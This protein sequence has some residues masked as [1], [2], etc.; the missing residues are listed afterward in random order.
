M[1]KVRFLRS[2]TLEDLRANIKDNLHLYREGDFT[3][4][5]VDTS[6]WFE[7]DID[8][9]EAKLSEIKA[10]ANG[11]L[12]EVENCVIAHEALANITPYEARDERLWSYLT[13]TSLLE[14][15]RDRWG[16]PVDEQEAINH[17][18]KHFF[19]R[20]KRQIERDNAASRLWWMGH[21]CSRIK[22]IELSDA[23]SAFLFKSDVRANI[24]ER[25]STSQSVSLFTALVKKLAES[26]DGNKKLF[27]RETFRRMMVEINSVGGSKLLDCLDTSQAEILLD[28]I[29]KH[30]LQIQA[31]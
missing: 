28:G 10:P 11:N 25:P 29:I 16:I 19:A 4:L 27:E 14:H 5:T 12:F 26:R 1:G 15:T 6:H 7:M 22:T 30:R 2:T 3:H 20:D 8:I 18:K 23:L 17:I 21:L 13:H 31:V 24:I 9:D